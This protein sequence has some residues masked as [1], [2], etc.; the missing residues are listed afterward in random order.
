MICILLVVFHMWYSPFM[1]T[2]GICNIKAFHLVNEMCRLVSTR[3][4]C[5][6]ITSPNFHTPNKG[7]CIIGAPMG[8]M[9]FEESFVIKAFQEDF[10]TI[11]NF[12][13]LTNPHVAFILLCLVPMLMIWV[14]TCFNAYVGINTLH[15]MI[16]LG[17]CCNY[18]F[19]EWNT[20]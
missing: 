8:F 10:N 5:I 11:I 18:Y 17:Y 12:L 2:N 7:F 3:I 4:I 9:S 13:M 20:H 1:I 15:P 6:H 19:G 16:L 14:S